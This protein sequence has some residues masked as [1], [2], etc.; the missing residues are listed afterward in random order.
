M[1]P[2]VYF[3]HADLKDQENLNAK[4]D[5][6]ETSSPSKPFSKEKKRMKLSIADEAMN[7]E[8]YEEDQSPYVVGI[9]DKSTGDI[10]VVDTSFFILKPECYISPSKERNGEN[11]EKKEI[12][13]FSDRLNSLTEAFGSSKKRKAM[14]TKIKNKLD[15]NTLE[16]AIGAA[17]KESIEIKKDAPEEEENIDGAA[18]EA[19][20]VL[21]VPNK[22]AKS[23]SEVYDI[24]Q[25]LVSKSEMDELTLKL[26]TK[27]VGASHEELTSWKKNASYPEFVCER[28]INVAA[29]RNSQFKLK[30]C[31]L[32]AYMNYLIAMYQLKSAQVR[33]KAPF[34]S[35]ADVSEALAK[36][37]LD[38]YT[39][40]ASTNASARSVRSM[41]RR[42]KDKL[43]A[44]IMILGL[45][46]DDFT[47]DLQALQKDLKISQQKLCEYYLAL[48][49]HVKNQAITVNN[50]KVVGKIAVLNLPLNEVKVV[51]KKR[52][53]K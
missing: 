42:L 49:C 52:A 18:T 53:R 33:A 32:L 16:E 1:L 4:F 24:E 31:K 20:S 38:G 12:R 7:Y 11:G 30:K 37:L 48:G 2:L 17:V 10:S 50:K 43:A 13:S 14:H 5:Q 40:S 34:S 27:F 41:P 23:P 39:V 29:S 15:S 46:I 51:A 28:L 6:V 8:A 22:A 45:T 36:K 19:F 9:F 35:V 3:T 47:T 26:A 21:P 25:I 44:H